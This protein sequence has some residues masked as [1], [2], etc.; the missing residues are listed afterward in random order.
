M[1]PPPLGPPSLI[2]EEPAE[3]SPELMPIANGGAAPEH[4][5][6]NQTTE[7]ELE[8]TA[9]LTPVYPYRHAILMQ[10]K[11]RMRSNETHYLDHPMLGLVVSITPLTAE[12]LQQRAELEI[13]QAVKTAQ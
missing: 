8:A 3:I 13:E 12:E 2:I 4:E 5:S 10:E 7:L 1:P 11:R 6:S 9:E